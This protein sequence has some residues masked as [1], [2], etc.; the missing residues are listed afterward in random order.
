MKRA[1]VGVALY[2]VAAFVM[3]IVPIPSIL[4]DVLLAFN[5]SIAFIVLFSCMFVKEVLDLAF[6]PTLLLFTTIHYEL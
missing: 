5:I 3:L 4:L 6:F 2:L 1:D